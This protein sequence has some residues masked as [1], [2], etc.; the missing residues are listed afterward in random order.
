MTTA[1]KEMLSAAVVIVSRREKPAV[2]R[3]NL[4]V[5]TAEL[6]EHTGR[7]GQVCGLI[8]GNLVTDGLMIRADGRYR[9]TLAGSAA[10]RDELA[11]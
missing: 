8:C 6:T 4:W 7:I 3:R 1:Q 9:L 5:S 10:L 2:G 11:A